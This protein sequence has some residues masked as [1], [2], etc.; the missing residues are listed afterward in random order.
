MVRQVADAAPQTDPSLLAALV[1]GPGPTVPVRWRKGPTLGAGSFGTVYLGLNCDTGELLAVKEVAAIGLEGAAAA[2]GPGGR[3]AG[4]GPGGAVAGPGGGGGPGEAVQQLEREVALLGSLRH[5]N[6]V[7]YVGTQRGDPGLPAGAHGSD[8]APLYIFLEYVPGGSVSSLLGRFGPLDEP[9]VALFTRQLVQGLAYLHAQRTVHRDIKGANLLLEKTGVLKVADF[10]MAKQIHEQ[11]SYT[12]SFKGSAFWMAPEVIK[13][14]GHG[15]AAD[16]WSVGC[17]VLEMATG[18]P[19]WSQCTSQVQAIFKIASSSDLPAIPER[20]SPLATEFVLL[21]LQRDPSARPSSEQLLRHPFL[22]QL[23]K[24]PS[25]PPA[26]HDPLNLLAHLQHHGMGPADMRAMQGGSGPGSG[27]QN[28]TNAFGVPLTIPAVNTLAG[29]GNGRP[30]SLTFA[31]HGSPA[32]HGVG[33]SPKAMG[34]P[35]G[36]NQNGRPFGGALGGSP[37][38]AALG[39]LMDDDQL[40]TLV[41]GDSVH[42]TKQARAAQQAAERAAAEEDDREELTIDFTTQPQHFRVR[43]LLSLPPLK[44]LQGG[45]QLPTVGFTPSWNPVAV[46]AAASSVSISTGRLSVDQSQGQ[47][48]QQTG[49]GRRI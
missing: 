48:Q 17:T 21:C 8:G 33:H 24:L 11:V 22:T 44:L 38:A 34:S 3:P 15:V 14:Q 26:L 20:L 31:V 13:Q 45:Q 43:G 23:L 35:L 36:L 4:S 6:I 28:P 46:A 37:T 19:P 42:I 40:A 1:L 49:G 16:I 32:A 27:P 30:G 7:K 47:Q 25:P 29:V 12:K 18:K 41:L 5:P 9:L 39:G 10:G 2:Q